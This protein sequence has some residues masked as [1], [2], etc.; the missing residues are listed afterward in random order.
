MCQ[1]HSCAYLETTTC[2]GSYSPPLGDGGEQEA[3]WG[4]DVNLTFDD[5]IVGSTNTY[6]LSEATYKEPTI[7]YN[8]KISE[9]TREGVYFT[10][11]GEEWSGPTHRMPGGM[12]MSG[13]PHDID[14][15]GSEGRSE[16]LTEIYTVYLTPSGK[17]WCG[18]M[19]ESMLGTIMSGKERNVWG[20]GPDGKSELLSK[21][22][23][24]NSLSNTPYKSCK[25]D[26]PKPSWD[27]TSI[28]C[29]LVPPWWPYGQFTG[30]NAYVDCWTRL[31]V[32]EMW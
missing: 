4:Y 22:T 9:D 14:G 21:N 31:S 13:N 27:C 20:S 8:K 15:S 32:V 17:Q 29:M 18:D 23:I 28:G 11:S 16:I 26:E 3:L 1:G 5:G 30:P 6:I 2:T 12:L 25:T 7:E 10:P 19:H 24:K